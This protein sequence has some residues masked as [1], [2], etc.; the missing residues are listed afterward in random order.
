MSRVLV[1]V[2]LVLA[3]TAA[4]SA[5][6]VAVDRW[7]VAASGERFLAQLETIDAQW[8]VT[9]HTDAGPRSLPAADLV[10]WGGR[11]DVQARAAVALSHGGVLVADTLGMDRDGLHASCQLWGQLSVS[12]EHVRGMLLHVPTSPAQLDRLL[13]QAMSATVEQ[14]LLL[15]DNGDTVSGDV[16]TLDQRRTLVR[17][18]STADLVIDTERVAAI[19]LADAH[20]AR[21]QR[22]V[23]IADWGSLTVRHCRWRK[24]C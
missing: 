2:L 4:S 6:D 14:D 19:L 24:R 18:G 10:R 9:L 22:A 23:R 15:L 11:V 17:S 16:T 1:L 7:A 21:R 12:L 5:A 3:A 8:R 13:Q 20:P